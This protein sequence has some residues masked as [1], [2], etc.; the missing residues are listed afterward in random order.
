MARFPVLALHSVRDD[1]D[2]LLVEQIE[3][4]VE[5]VMP[6]P[7]YSRSAEAIAQNTATQFMDGLLHQ[8]HL[9]SAPPGL[10]GGFLDSCLSP[11]YSRVRMANR[12]LLGR[13]RFG[14]YCSPIPGAGRQIDGRLP[15][16]GGLPLA[17]VCHAW[18]F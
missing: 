5:Y 10:R 18:V 3:Q 16:G 9:V 8:V 12:S 15:A 2:R 4:R 1:G 7:C 13:L 11:R 6:A 14:V 17:G